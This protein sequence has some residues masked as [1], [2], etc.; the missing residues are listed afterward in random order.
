MQ[1]NIQL[2]PADDVFELCVGKQRATLSKEVVNKGRK[3]GNHLAAL[4]DDDRLYLAF[5][6]DVPSSFQLMCL[7]RRSRC[8]IWETQVWVIGASIFHF[9]PG[10][11]HAVGI[12]KAN[13]QVLV[14]GA[15]DGCFY[16]EGF[17]RGW[18]LTISFQHT[19]EATE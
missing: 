13:R 15:G 19:V 1:R 11:G 3:F 7:D 6:D 8:V 10:S 12:L 2:I 4:I 14:F 18:T 17:A 5:H 16:V 9:G